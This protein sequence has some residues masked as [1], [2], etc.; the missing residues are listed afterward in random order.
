MTKY[1]IAVQKSRG[2]HLSQEA[3]CAVRIVSYIVG[4]KLFDLKESW[5]NRRP[6][7]VESHKAVEDT[8]VCKC[9]IGTP[10][11]PVWYVLRGYIVATGYTG[12]KKNHP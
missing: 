6:R 2:L 9:I 7:R 4:L 10:R 5:S 1:L 8:F 3:Q 12:C 11:W